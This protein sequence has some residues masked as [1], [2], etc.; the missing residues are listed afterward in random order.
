MKIITT[1]FQEGGRFMSAFAE[2]WF[3]EGME[4]GVLLL[5]KS[6]TP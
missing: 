1:E 2:Q 5:Q 4:K 3:N 6:S